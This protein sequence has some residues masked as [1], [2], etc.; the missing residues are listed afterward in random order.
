MND[1]LPMD[2]PDDGHPMWKRLTKAQ[3]AAMPSWRAAALGT[4]ARNLVRFEGRSDSARI[5][6][7]CQRA[8]QWAQ[9]AHDENEFLNLLIQTRLAYVRTATEGNASGSARDVNVIRDLA[10]RL[11]QSVENCDYRRDLPIQPS[12]HPGP[13]HEER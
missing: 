10:E 2:V 7:F 1:T 13:T 5:L 8:Y 6:A 3:T 12:I 9:R 11:V 4:L